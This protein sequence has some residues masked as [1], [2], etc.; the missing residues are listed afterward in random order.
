M[1]VIVGFFLLLFNII[2][3]I[4][5]H[6]YIHLITTTQYNK[7]HLQRELYKRKNEAREIHSVT[8]N[9]PRQK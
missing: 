6:F 7:F 3:N 1:C 9:N 8:Q 2:H 5:L 4:N